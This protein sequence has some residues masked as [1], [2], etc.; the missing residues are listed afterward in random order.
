MSSF[1]H[2]LT[3]ANA[4]LASQFFSMSCFFF[5][6]FFVNSP[7]ARLSFVSLCDGIEFRGTSLPPRPPLQSFTFYTILT[8]FRVGIHRFQ[9]GSRAI[10]EQLQSSSKAI[11][12]QLQSSSKAISGQFQ[13]RFKTAAIF[14]IRA[15]LELFQVSSRAVLELFQVS[16][17]AVQ[18]LFRVSFRAVLW[19]V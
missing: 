16:F 14:S 4:G 15:V 19:Q 13:S 9:S 17:R 12:E 18:K 10:S 1:S 11:S 6:V 3:T 8:Q 2:S 5:V 7:S